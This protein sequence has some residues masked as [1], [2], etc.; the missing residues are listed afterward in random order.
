MR[1]RDD[2]TVYWG[3]KKDMTVYVKIFPFVVIYLVFSKLRWVVDFAD[4]CS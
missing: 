2:T 1:F 3:K 4:I